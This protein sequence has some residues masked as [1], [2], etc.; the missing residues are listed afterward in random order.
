[1]AES[2]S[3]KVEEGELVRLLKEGE[4]GASLGGQGREPYE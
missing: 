1:M 4:V 3:S 2:E